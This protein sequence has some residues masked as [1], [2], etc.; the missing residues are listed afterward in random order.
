ML[1]IAHIASIAAVEVEKIPSLAEAIVQAWN[2]ALTTGPVKSR[3]RRLILVNFKNVRSDDKKGQVEPG[4]PSL[5]LID[6]L[7]TPDARYFR[8]FFL[9]LLWSCLE[10]RASIEKFVDPLRFEQSVST[11]RAAYRTYIYAQ[12]RDSLRALPDYSTN[13]AALRKKAKDSTDGSLSKAI[14]HWF[15][16]DAEKSFQEWCA[17]QPDPEDR[18]ATRSGNGDD[19]GADPLES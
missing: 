2:A 5:N 6:K 17:T 19:S 3:D 9:E 13:T 1:T 15:G 10:S 4:Q 12:T 18:G 7:D 8:Y 16:A 14:K 11:A